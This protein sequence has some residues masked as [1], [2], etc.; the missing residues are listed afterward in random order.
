MFKL[1][2]SML[3]RA[4]HDLFF[5]IAA[6]LVIL[7][8][9]FFFGN[10]TKN[11]KNHVPSSKDKS[12]IVKYEEEDPLIVS[13][14]MVFGPDS[15]FYNVPS[16]DVIYR[17]SLSNMNST[18]GGI[19]IV[20]ILVFVFHVLY[21][22]YFFGE[23]YTKGAIRN[24]IAAGSSKRNIFLASLLAN[25][26]LL[27]EFALIAAAVILV[28]ILVCGLYPIIYVPAVTVYLLALYLIGLVLSSF[29]V[30]VVFITQRPL[31]AFLAV[32]GCAVLLFFS[33]GSASLMTAFETKYEPDT[34]AWQAFCKE[35]KEHDLGFEWYLPV[36]D[37][38]L[39]GIK[40][41]DGTVYDDFLSDKPNNEYEGDTKAAVARV[42]WRLNICSILL[43]APLFYAYP[44]FRDGVFLRY[45]A[46]SSVYLCLI[47]AVGVIV[48]KRRDI[49]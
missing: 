36:N 48:V 8:T 7:S 31:M 19:F 4:A 45:I 17:D 49:I 41:A 42:L 30:L 20:S 10:N 9:I 32:I 16:Q 25:A 12:V 47:T 35:A 14:H 15:Y 37:F 18:E 43:E 21:G 34:K 27:I 29:V 44:L 11:M 2:K 28:F 39:Y 6:G 13:K 26:I 38:N 3:Y 1:V 46:V 24:Y 23:L 33:F 22:V 40:K 5:Y